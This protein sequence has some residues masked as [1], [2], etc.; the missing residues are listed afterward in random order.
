MSLA[1]EARAAGWWTQYDDLNLDP[2]IGLEEA[3][4]D[5]SCYSMNYIPGLLQTE[6]YAHGIIKTIAPKMEPR[7]VQQRVEA[8]LRRQEVLEKDNPPRYQVLLDESILRR[9]VGGPMIMAAQIKKVLKAVAS[10]KVIVQIIP[11][12]EARM[13]RQMDISCCKSSQKR[14]IC[15][16]WFSL[17]AWQ[18]TSTMTARA[19]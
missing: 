19:I 9:G 14:K 6:E 8:R 12:D 17:R 11:F 3:A 4:T 7:I 2:L 18:A 1:R 10:G 15:G 5:I 13:L 16:R